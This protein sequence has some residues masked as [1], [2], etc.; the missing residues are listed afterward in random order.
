MSGIFGYV[1]EQNASSVIL[2]GL[3]RL[4]YHGYDTAGIVV[5]TPQR[6]IHALYA[7]GK[8]SN[9]EQS[10][11]MNPVHAGYGIGQANW[12]SGNPDDVENTQREFGG[13][14]GIVVVLS[15]QIYNLPKLKKKLSSTTAL[16]QQ[17]TATEVVAHLISN[18]YRDGALLEDALQLA[19]K[20]I[21]G[22]FM[23][24][25]I[26]KNQPNNIVVAQHGLPALVGIGENEYFVAS[27]IPAILHQTK[28]MIKLEENDLA[29]LSSSGV[30]VID[31][32]SFPTTRPVQHILW[33]SL[34]TDK[35][36]YKNF[37]L[38]EI[39]EQPRA[40]RDTAMGRIDPQNGNVFLAE[41]G[42][43]AEELREIRH[44]NIIASGSSWHAGLAGKGMIEELAR[45]HVEVEYGSEFRYSDPLI[46]D[47]VL[48]I[49]ISQS[50][51]TA[52]T[53][54]SQRLA[55]KKGSKTI[56]IC[57]AVD[58]SISSTALGSIFTFA[59]PE[60]ASSS[61]KT[62]TA[63]LTAMF[64]FGMYLGQIRSV[65]SEEDSKKYAQELLSLPIL[66]ESALSSMGF[67][68]YLARQ[69]WRV[70]KFLFLGR[71]IHFPIAL[72]GAR[73]LQELSYRPAEGCAAGEMKHGPSALIDSEMLVVA[74]ATQ[75]KN[76]PASC[77][78]YK[79]MLKQIQ[80]VTARQGRIICI[81]NEGDTTPSQYANEVIYIPKAC[82][83]LLPILEIIPLQL[84]AY[85]IALQYGCNVDQPRNI[86]KSVTID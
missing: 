35:S 29:I 66:V 47:R 14:N 11:Q 55:Q 61:T 77:V 38:K 60:L 78:R 10:A 65:L 1:G 27:E 64:L 25:A 24:A 53:L 34:M 19:L 16:H 57:N 54:A 43:T 69:F 4:E 37:M 62:F 3:R 15:G 18:N 82:E 80:E 7:Q 32:D 5:V 73:K 72:E 51:E 40:I 20:N 45:V 6:M 26:S 8:L 22:E 49:A 58:S 75:D 44:L 68:E 59:G 74:L 63:Q 12:A 83:L 67:C 76:H 71:G 84:L 21:N 41:L 50:G 86:A 30:R 79:K 28:D 48:T 81:A 9:L 56:A 23:L 42:I 13:T 2:E 39:F 85:S 36:G 70:S 52:D 33:D 31:S 46:D 17:T